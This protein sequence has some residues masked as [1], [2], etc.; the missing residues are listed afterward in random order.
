[1][2]MASP[3]GP[4]P[5][6]RSVGSPDLGSLRWAPAPWMSTQV[7]FMYP[8]ATRAGSARINV[9]LRYGHMKEIHV[10]R[11][12]DIEPD[13]DEQIGVVGAAPADQVRINFFFY[14]PLGFFEV[15]AG[16]FS[17]KSRTLPSGSSA[18]ALGFTGHGNRNFYFTQDRES[19]YQIHQSRSIRDIAHPRGAAIFL[20]RMR[21]RR[22]PFVDKRA[23]LLDRRPMR[24]P[25]LI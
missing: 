8:I 18:R 9:D 21:L 5:V 25:L 6:G 23:L 13:L 19:L 2:R 20:F 10:Y 12:G 17:P 7:P 1:M 4:W 3:W 24:T 14:Y 15:Q 22:R 16:F 11:P